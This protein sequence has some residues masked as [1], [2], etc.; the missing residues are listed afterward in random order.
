MERRVID[1][2]TT[3]GPWERLSVKGWRC[4][5]KGAALRAAAVLEGVPGRLRLGPGGREGQKSLFALP[6][7]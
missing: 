7:L 4:W 2:E 6:T 1:G 3:D 5:G